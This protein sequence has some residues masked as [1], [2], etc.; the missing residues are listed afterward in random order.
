[1]PRK[2]VR[3]I[4]AIIFDIEKN[5]YSAAQVKF[6]TKF[7]RVNPLSD[8]LRGK[9]TWISQVKGINDSVY[10]GLAR[11]YNSLFPDKLLRIGQSKGEIRD[12]ANWVLE[13]DANDP[14]NS[15]QGSAFF[16]QDYGLISAFHCVE[17]A[18][19]IEI[20]HPHHPN[21]RYPV[22]IAKFCKQRDLVVLDHAVPKGQ[23]LNLE[24]AVRTTRT[25]DLVR[26]LGFPSFGPGSS[27][28]VRDGKIVAHQTKSAV[29]QLVVDGKINQGNSGG[30]I[31]DQNDRVVGVAHKGGPSEAIDIAIAIRELEGF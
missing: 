1:M 5:G 20:F 29:K 23:F 30:P 8:H 25:G 24:T 7:H 26:I 9:I 14:K 19:K 22:S 27:L 11:R 10:M 17:G 3:N 4:R 28:Q 31:V 13:K 6:S 21:L 16:L 2:Y 12:L 18:K 15:S